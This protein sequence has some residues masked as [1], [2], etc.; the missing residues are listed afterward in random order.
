MENELKK[1]LQCR[2]ALCKTC[3]ADTA[4]PEAIAIVRKAGSDPDAMKTAGA[5]LF[6]NNPFTAITGEICPNHLY[7]LNTCILNRKGNPVDFR[8]IEKA[9]SGRFLEN[10]K[11]EIA[12]LKSSWHQTPSKK[13]KKVLI[14]GSGPA[15]LSTAYYL[16]RAGFA[17]TVYEKEQ[18]FGG[19]LQ[20]GIPDFRLDKTL[21]DKIVDILTA[22]GVVLKPNTSVNLSNIETYK[23]NFDIIILAIGACVSKTLDIKGAQYAVNALD[24]LHSPEKPNIQKAKEVIVIGAGNVAIDCALTAAHYGAKTVNL[25]YRRDEIAMKA[26]PEELALAREKGVVFNYHMVPK[27]ITKDG[28]IF[29]K[30]LKAKSKEIFMPADKVI[31]AIGQTAVPPNEQN[32][33]EKIKVSAGLIQITENFQ[34]N[35]ENIYSIGDAVTGTSTVIKA[36]AAAKALAIKI[37]DI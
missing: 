6:D 24:Y 2:N 28:V 25:C 16:N 29:E 26:Y 27:E 5:L 33:K 4:I 21:I 8:I 37:I 17:V 3:P 1:C 10:Y 13:P 15:G 22:I 12:N 31:I 14:V 30:T 20:Y 34:T 11:A 36:V 18:K 9:V 19:M 35:L 23:K 32:N 7:C